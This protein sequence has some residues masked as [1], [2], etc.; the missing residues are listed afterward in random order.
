MSAEAPCSSEALLWRPRWGADKRETGFPER[1]EHPSRAKS[2][3]Y[4]GRDLES[5]VC[6]EEMWP[7]YPWAQSLRREDLGTLWDSEKEDLGS[8]EA[9]KGRSEFPPGLR[10][11][12]G[13]GHP[14]KE[15]SRAPAG[16]QRRTG[17]RWNSGKGDGGVPCHSEKIRGLYR[18]WER[19]RWLEDRVES[20]D[21]GCWASKRT[22]AKGTRGPP[23]GSH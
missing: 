1:S 16:A 14:Q 5:S 6:L 10:E 8:R 21:G 7:G 4:S 2:L 22:G 19:G 18:A 23:W 12:V 11:A 20:R 15:K 13:P 17:P 3:G 9:P